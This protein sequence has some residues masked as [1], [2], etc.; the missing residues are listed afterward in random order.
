MQI[1][2]ST[3]PSF[4]ASFHSQL[5]WR[6]QGQHREL[7]WMQ[8]FQH[9]K[10]PSARREKVQIWCI[11]AQGHAYLGPNDY[12]YGESVASCKVFVATL[13]FSNCLKVL[14][15]LK[16]CICC[17]LASLKCSHR[18]GSNMRMAA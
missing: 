16:M 15:I 10:H 14:D 9:T 11:S 17:T 18:K 2:A 1:N 5:G 7:L 13:V 6:G 4:L 8:T 12:R 3:P